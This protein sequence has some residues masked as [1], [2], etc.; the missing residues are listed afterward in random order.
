MQPEGEQY[1]GIDISEWQ[2]S[3]D[4]SAAKASGIETVYIRSTIGADGVDSRFEQNYQRARAAGIKTGF[5]HYLTARTQEQARQQ[6]HFFVQT[7]SGK[8]ADMRLAM[9]FESFGSLD[10]QQINA[11]ALAF[12]TTVE[13]LSG[14]IP[15]VYSDANDA[16]E[17]WDSSLARYPLWVAQWGVQQPSDNPIWNTWIG[18]QYSDQGNIPGI[19]GRV[20]LDLF[21]SGAF[22][23]E[24][25]SLPEQVEP[26]TVSVRRGDTLWGIAQRYGTTVSHLAALNGIRNPDLIYPGQ[27]LKLTGTPSSGGT[28][29][30][31]RTVTV[32]RGDTL[33]EI[34]Q[35]YGTTVSHLAALNGIRNPDLIYP[36][37][38]LK[39][40]GTPSS[41]G[42]ENMGRTVTVRRGD[43]L[44]GI[45]QRYG[46]TVSYLTAL[47]GIRNPE[48]I[49][50]GQKIR[51]P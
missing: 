46:T 18:F 22:L 12:L 50:P 5:Y 3:I 35:R 1:R 43:T 45:A 23:S 17:L 14:H 11:I 51:L 15:A 39:L 49:Y 10:R 36:G 19:S 26:M 21:T 2:G 28:E 4:F 33:W 7:V 42:T 8:G 25:E 40:T 20:D 44:W 30:A 47:N 38:V 48:R 24:E 31:G 16:R 34:A 37:Q 29:N 32:R 41:G 27:V 13:E 9:D 6:A